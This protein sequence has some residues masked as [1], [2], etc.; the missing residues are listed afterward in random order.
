[1]LPTRIIKEYIRAK[2]ITVWETY[3]HVKIKNL[4]VV[5]FPIA[6]YLTIHCALFS[7]AVSTPLVV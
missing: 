1:M 5:I 3:T 7:R 6:L 4:K 2:H